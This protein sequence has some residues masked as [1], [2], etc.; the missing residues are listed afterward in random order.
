MLIDFPPMVRAHMFLVE[1]NRDTIDADY[2][3]HFVPRDG[4]GP[5]EDGYWPEGDMEAELDPP[6]F[7]TAQ[8]LALAAL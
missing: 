3:F 2:Q 4:E 1:R 5:D 6:S 7:W 8:V